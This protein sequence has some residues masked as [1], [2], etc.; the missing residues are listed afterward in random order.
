MTGFDAEQIHNE[1]IRNG[2]ADPLRSVI[3]QALGAASACWDN[4]EGAGV[5]KDREAKQVGDDLLAFIRSQLGDND[6][7]EVYRD[8]AGRYRYRIVARNGRVVDSATQGYTTRYGAKRAARRGRKGIAVK[9]V[10]R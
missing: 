8:V 4:L 7:A 10:R 5:F 1:A 9:Q 6:R 3:F 2:E